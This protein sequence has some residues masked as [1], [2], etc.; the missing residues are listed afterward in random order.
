MAMTR[1]EAAALIDPTWNGVVYVRTARKEYPCV[2]AKPEKTLKI[3]VDHGGGHT[4]TQYADTPEGAE[5]K[6]GKLAD[7]YPAATVKVEPVPN[8]EYQ[9]GC[10]GVIKPGD[11]H[12]EYLGEAPAYQSGTRY[13]QRCGIKA[14][15]RSGK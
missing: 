13:C 9:D 1:A 8:P 2:G 3:I 14:W 10:Q 12:I 6:R 15:G 5:F 7:Q 4:S 11:V